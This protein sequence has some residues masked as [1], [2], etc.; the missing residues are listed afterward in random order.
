MEPND[1]GLVAT[2]HK[3]RLCNVVRVYEPRRGAARHRRGDACLN[4][5]AH[6]CP[7]S[8]SRALALVIA[9]IQLRGR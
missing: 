1:H 2:A 3:S 8:N 7:C 6:R 9:A 4:I 5:L